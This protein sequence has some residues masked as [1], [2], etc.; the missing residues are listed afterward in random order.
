M[1]ESLIQLRAKG[2]VI[3]FTLIEIL[4][5][6]MIIAIAAMVAVPMMSSAA[7][8]QVRAA[9]NQIAAD[10]EYAKSMAISRQ[11][12]Y[13]VV[14][15][16]DAES[17]QIEE[18]NGAVISHPVKKGFSYIVNFANDGR[19]EGVDIYEVDFDTTSTIKFDFLG[20]PCN[21]SNNPLNNGVITLK[22]G[23]QTMTI[24]VSPVTGYIS[25]Q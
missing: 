4:V 1:S 18:P 12:S 7:S 16:K 8:F 2:C 23:E 22:A 25:I 5:V 13:S 11:Q 3:G 20:S 19:T 14:F 15:D 10:M 6:V 24:N 9:A 21:G 17:Y